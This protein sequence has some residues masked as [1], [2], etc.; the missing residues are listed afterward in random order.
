[1]MTKLKVFLLLMALISGNQAWAIWT[2]VPSPAGLC[3]SSYDIKVN[4]PGGTYITNDC[5]L[6]VGNDN[7]VPATGSYEVLY[8]ATS[9]AGDPMYAQEFST[10]SQ[11]LTAGKPLS[12]QN[13]TWLFNSGM[14]YYSVNLNNYYLCYNLRQISTGKDF[15]FKNTPQGCLKTK[16]GGATPLPPPPTPLSCQF[17]S[18]NPINVALGEIS[19]N[20][21]G[22]VPGTLPGMEK[23]LDVNCAG[24]GSA[25]YSIKFQFT[26]KEVAGSELI[27]SSVNGLAVA[28]SFN[29][30]VVSNTDSFSR[31]YS[32]GIQTETLGFE[33]VRDPAVEYTDIPTGA[34][35]AS[36][37]MVITQE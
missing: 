19:R 33:P 9:V 6:A 16:N 5:T 2:G 27:T 34:F 15:L 25:T 3:T 23:K 29:D 37:V 17:N 18:G 13:I 32:A 11:T 30:S 4:I 10:G 12:E 24:D 26:P 8:Y 36:A 35:T 21:I 7:A 1:M 20:E 31:T 22:T 28:L 14:T